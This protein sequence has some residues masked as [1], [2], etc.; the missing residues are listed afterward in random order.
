M[1]NELMLDWIIIQETKFAKVFYNRHRL[2]QSQGVQMTLR[3]ALIVPE[4]RRLVGRQ[5]TPATSA[6][7]R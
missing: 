1:V 2:H 5:L 7:K 6:S 4:V 3:E